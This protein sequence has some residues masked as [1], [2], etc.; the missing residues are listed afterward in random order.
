MSDLQQEVR[1]FCRAH[2]LKI[3]PKLGQHF[4]IDQSVLDSIINAA[5]LHNN[6]N[7]VE[8]GAGIGILT[9]ALLDS[10]CTVTSIEIDKGLIPLLKQFTLVDAANRNL[11]IL[12]Q[13]A[14][15]VPMPTEP[16][17]VVANIPY[18][19][20]SPLLRHA[21]L[22]SP[23]HPTSLTLLIQ[24]EVAEKICDRKNAS[25]LTIIVGL[26][27]TPKIVKTVPPKAF[28]PAPKVDSAVLH[29]DSFAEPLAEIPVIE[30]VMQL[31]K[32]AFSQKRKMLRKTIGANDDGKKAMDAVAIE[33]TRRPQTLSVDEWISLAKAWPRA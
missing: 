18:H 25:L 12:V 6:E 7:V 8:V 21:F 15:E 2:G 32:T 11:T 33:D 16:Y 1:Q 3:N 22:E 28:L 23:M 10:G 20:T 31:A 4:L 5:D 29:I 17:K 24:Q 26:F 27:G 19:I 30:R 13:N 14:L 9:R